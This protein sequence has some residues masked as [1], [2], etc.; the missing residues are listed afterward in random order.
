[1]RLAEEGR[2]SAHGAGDPERAAASC[3]ARRSSLWRGPP[4]ADFAYEP[5]AQQEI[6]RLEELRLAALEDRIDADLA[7]RPA[8]GAGGRAGGSRRART[9][10]RERLRA[11]A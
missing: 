2:A 7:P 1:M 8:R 6:G 4:L 10:L 9:R 5:F 3:C 11:S